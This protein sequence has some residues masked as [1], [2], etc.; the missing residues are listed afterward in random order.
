MRR[1]T[2]TAFADPAQLEQVVINLVKNAREAAG[3]EGRVEVTTDLIDGGT[4][5]QVLDDGPGLAASVLSEV[6]VPFFTTKDSGTG[7]GL[8]L[9]REVVE[10]H[11]GRF[12]IGNRDGGGAI[13]TVWVPGPEGGALKARLTISRH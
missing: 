12:A 1:R 5:L 7:L 3:P 2:A 10:A 4:R 9:C 13:A 8:T 11:G 6:G